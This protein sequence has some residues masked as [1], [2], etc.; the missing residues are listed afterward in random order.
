[1]FDDIKIDRERLYKLYME[2]VDHIC[3]ECD[4]VSSF[5]PRDIISIISRLI[6]S[7]PNLISKD[8]V[9]IR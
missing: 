4:W 8:N 2:E 1:M 9:H 6:E 7:N 3:E 5:T